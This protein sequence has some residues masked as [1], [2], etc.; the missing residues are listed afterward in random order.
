MVDYTTARMNMVDSQ[1][2]TNRVTDPRVLDAFEEVPRER[3]VPRHL[4]PIAYVDEDLKI[5]EE[6]Y[7]MEPM[8]LA[9]L[10]D[11]AEIAADDVVLVVG[12][13]TGY[14]CALVARIAATVVGLES[15]RKLAGQA[16][17]TLDELGADN[18]VIVTGD[19][20]KGYPKQAP[21][22]VVLINGAVAEVPR[23]MTDELA[24]GGRLLTVLKAGP[25]MGKAVRF[26]RVGDA[27]G[28]RTLFDAA[29]PILPGF[30]REPGFVF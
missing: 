12:A 25:G 29:T 16:E 28:R 30:E 7:L 18:A 24:E 26:E 11:A 22:N 15:D 13:A 8:V 4:Q 19:L 14:S 6:R 21:Y 5:T 9:R 3:F 10:L 20:A 23:R 27:V 1:L 2:R 17:K